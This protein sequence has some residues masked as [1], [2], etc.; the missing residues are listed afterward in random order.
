LLQGEV[1]ETRRALGPALSRIWRLPTKFEMVISLKTAK[2]LGL[3]IPET[4][5]RSLS[6]LFVNCSPA[7]AT[8]IPVWV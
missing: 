7:V 2:P 4:S 3:T 8:A 6:P 5:H 1:I